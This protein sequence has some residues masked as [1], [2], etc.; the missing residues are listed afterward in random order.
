MSLLGN[1]LKGLMLNKNC[2][3]E[4]RFYLPRHLHDQN[5]FPSRNDICPVQEC[6]VRI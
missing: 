6:N 2:S 4:L 5:I 3:G 1:L